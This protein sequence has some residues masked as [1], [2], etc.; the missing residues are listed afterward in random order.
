MRVDNRSLWYKVLTARYGEVG[1][2]NITV[3][4]WRFNS[5]WWNNLINIKNGVDVGGGR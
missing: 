5:V 2:I 4:E 1:G 3:E